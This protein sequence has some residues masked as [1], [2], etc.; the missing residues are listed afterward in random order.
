MNAGRSVNTVDL[1]ASIDLP[2]HEAERLMIAATGLR[3]TDVLLGADLTAAQAERLDELVL[4]RSAG[5]PLQYLEGSVQFGPLELFVDRRVLIPRPETERLW[6]IVTSRLPEAPHVVVDLCTG[7]GNLALA[8]KHS[9]PGAT[10]YATDEDAGALE[11]AETNARKNGL[12]VEFL[13]GDLFEAL[14]VEIH[15]AADVLVA[16]PPYVAEADFAGLPADVRDHE[17][18]AAL[19]GGGDGLEV[20]RRIAAEA[21][22][23]LRPGGLIVCEIGESQS[24]A[25][26]GL[27]ARFGAEVLPDL[28]GRP[29]FV[30]G[31]RPG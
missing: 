17:P 6:E 21:T 26:A 31:H 24:A 3:R 1:L 29:R 7:S 13:H 30:T 11:V 8:L 15:E 22:A 20:L 25:A 5:E 12:D 19:I 27:F 23:W 16:N 4:R 18:P 10:V 2:R 14:P 28:A 9:W